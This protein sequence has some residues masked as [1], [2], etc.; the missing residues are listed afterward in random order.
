M[1][2]EICNP[3]LIGDKNAIDDGIRIAGTAIK[4]R[5][6]ENVSDANFEFGVIDV[7]DLKNVDMKEMKY[8]K[9]NAMCGKASGEYIEKAVDLALKKEINAITTC[10]IHKDS[11]QS[12][13]Y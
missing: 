9:V 4:T 5:S 7:L 8:G 12:G 1:I 6:I 2:Y 3:V 10:P 13:G 11:F